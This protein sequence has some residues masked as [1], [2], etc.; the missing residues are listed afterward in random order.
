MSSKEFFYLIARVSALSGCLGLLGGLIK[1]KHLSYLPT[2]GL[3]LSFCALLSD[4][5]SQYQS[6]HGLSNYTIINTY[7]VAQ[8]TLIPFLFYKM[9]HARSMKLIFW[10]LVLLTLITISLA[11]NDFQLWDSTFNNKLLWRSHAILGG[12]CLFYFLDKLL[13]DKITPLFKD[14]NWWMSVG[15]L[16]Y[17]TGTFLIFFT[18]DAIAKNEE[19]FFTLLVLNCFLTI[20]KNTLIAY[21]IWKS[22]KT[23]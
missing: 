23:S 8:A 10:I 4:Q 2:W 1:I 3:I 7:A 5:M 22:P 21:M 15:L 18:L 6:F 20:N 19:L 16:L 11:I 14:P 12:F 17:A 9:I 13:E